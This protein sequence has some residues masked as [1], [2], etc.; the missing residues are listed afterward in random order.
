MGGGYRNKIES[1][2]NLI[3]KQN[4]EEFFNLFFYFD[5]M[6]HAS[7]WDDKNKPNITDLDFKALNNL[8]KKKLEINAFDNGYDKYIN[9]T[10]K[11]YTNNQKKLVINLKLINNQYKILEDLIIYPSLLTSET[12][13]EKKENIQKYNVFKKQIL[14]LFPNI[15]HIIIQSAVYNFKDKKTFEYSFDLLLLLKIISNSLLFK[16]NNLKITIKATHKYGKVDWNKKECEYI[17][18]S[19]LSNVLFPNV[20]KA[21]NDKNLNIGLTESS[22]VWGGVTFREDCIII[23]HR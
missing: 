12:K 21:F 8:I 11:L 20:V 18:A 14:E 3:T 17:G 2:R 23:T 7:G 10:F 4:F 22:F 1:I 13:T 5:C 19:W 9:D 6:I 16:T 15:N